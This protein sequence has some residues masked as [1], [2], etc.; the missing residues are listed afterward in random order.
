MTVKICKIF[1]VAISALCAFAVTFGASACSN[2]TVTPSSDK[3]KTHKFVI[4]YNYKNS[5][6]PVSQDVELGSVVSEPAAPVRENYNFKG[7]FKNKRIVTKYDFSQPI[8]ADTTIYAGWTAQGAIITYDYNYADAP[9]AQRVSVSTC[10]PITQP[11]APERAGF[12]FVGWY[13][14]SSGTTAFLFENGIEKNTTVF[15]K[16]SENVARVTFNYNY[17]GA[18]E[19]TYA[20]VDFGDSVAE[21]S[22]PVR[23]RYLFD[24][25]YEDKECTVKFDF[26]TKL[27]SSLTLY[28]GWKLV[29]PL[30]TFAGNY[31]GAVN[32][33][34]RLNAVNDSVQKPTNPEREGY[35][36]VSW[37]TDPECTTEYNF[38]SS[39]ENDLTLYAGWER[40]SLVVTFNMNYEGSAAT[41]SKVLYGDKV[42]EPEEPSRTGYTFI[43]WFKDAAGTAAYDFESTVTGNFTL[44]AGW[45]GD[46][47]SGNVTVRFKNNY[48][49]D[50]TSDYTALSLSVGDRIRVPSTNPEREG[51]LFKGWYTSKDFTTKFV[52]G[53]RATGDTNIYARWLKQYTFEAEY[54]YLP[55]DK[56]ALGTS[57][58]GYGPDYI[59]IDVAKEME[60][61][62]EIQASNNYFVSNLFYNG[63]FIEFE[64]YSPVDVDDAVLSLR[65][66][67]DIYDTV[68]TPSTYGITVNGEAIDYAGIILD[69][70]YGFVTDGSPKNGLSNKR[71]FQNYI[72][73]EGLNL[74]AG[75]NVIRLTTLNS[76]DHGG[77]YQAETPAVDCMYIYSD[78]E[79]KWAEGKCYESNL[80]KLS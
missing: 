6:D 53:T 15:A 65:L 38:A 10:E 69:N 71:T 44:Y 20:S 9:V 73:T 33:A 60:N 42:Q 78:V 48:S 45:T 59:I 8:M 1:T 5:P 4:D 55:D 13:T 51:Y 29:N 67:P 43:G 80:N 75:N 63:A 70:A 3:I 11:S 57:D 14:T 34:S 79:I 30:V 21:I 52:T 23:D 31:E 19:N 47:T 7:W 41:T 35:N 58:N 76:V 32:T 36:F 74:K 16:W 22:T 24:G 64:V 68:L 66:T 12:T 37:Y 26:N 46:D 2:E 49:D 25:W 40:K 50:D 54:T 17:D 18:P 61:G 72:I 28:A 62:D 27:N 77:T 56:L 39:V